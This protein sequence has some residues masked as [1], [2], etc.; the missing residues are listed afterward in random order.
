VR[1]LSFGLPG[2]TDLT[3]RYVTTPVRPST[4]LLTPCSDSWPGATATPN[5]TPICGR[6]MKISYGAKSVVVRV[7]DRCE[8]CAINDVDLSKVAFSQLAAFDVGRMPVT[9]RF[10]HSP[11]YL[12][13]DML[14]VVMGLRIE[15]RAVRDG[16]GHCIVHNVI[17]RRHGLITEAHPNRHLGVSRPHHATSAS[18]WAWGKHGQIRML[19]RRAHTR[20]HPFSPARWRPTRG[21]PDARRRRRTG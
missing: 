19:G 16:R 18:A 5:T 11:P 2:R 4:P 1:P 3:H 6:T 7:Q 10:R 20:T 17:H 15:S 12:I 21:R 8:G 14:A 13:T 9:V